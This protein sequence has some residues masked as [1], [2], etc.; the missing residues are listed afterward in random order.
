MSI[1]TNPSAAPARGPAEH[2]CLASPSALC[3]VIILAALDTVDEA[4]LH[5]IVTLCSFLSFGKA[6]RAA[7]IQRSASAKCADPDAVR[8]LSRRAPS[9]VQSQRSTPKPFHHSNSPMS[10]AGMAEPAT[11]TSMRCGAQLGLGVRYGAPLT[12]L[13]ASSSWTYTAFLP[14]R[15]LSRNCLPA[16]AVHAPTCAMHS[17][18]AL[19]A[20]HSSSKCECQRAIGILHLA[21][22]H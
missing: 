7:P 13:I 21:L 15:H 22:R 14:K 1:L 12:V 6:I 19:S 11:G 16:P 18:S 5:L 17:G 4:L 2:K 10:T 3:S 9:I 8:C 20:S